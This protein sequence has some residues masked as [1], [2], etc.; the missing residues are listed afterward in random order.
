M[1]EIENSYKLKLVDEKEF[2]VH[3]SLFYLIIPLL[4]LSP[5]H[6]MH[7]LYLAISLLHFHFSKRGAANSYITNNFIETCG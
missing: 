7:A 2:K 3:F 6:L 4:S 1:Q 5:T